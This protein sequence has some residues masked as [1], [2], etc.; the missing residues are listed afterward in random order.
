[1]DKNLR[2]GV[3][4]TYRLQAEDRDGLV[5]DASEVVT[6]Q[7]K[8]RPR[9]PEGLKGEVS[10]TQT[11]LQ[12]EPSAEADIAFY[13]IYQKRFFLMNR[14]GHSNLP[15]YTDG[16]IARGRS[17]TYVVTAVDQDGLESPPS[18]E[19]RLVGR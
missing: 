10:T 13:V 1:V 12:W 8:P 17:R 19:L 15:S 11:E 9:P 6:L 4:Y 14:L 2:D 3:T 16:P 18:E 5:S 7:T